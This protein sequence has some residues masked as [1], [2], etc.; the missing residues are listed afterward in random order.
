MSNNGENNDIVQRVHC[1]QAS[2]AQS[3]ARPTG[4]QEVPDSIPAGSGNIDEEIFSLPSTIQ[5]GQ[6]SVSGKRMCT[7]TG[8]PLRGLSLPRKSVVR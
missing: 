8:K 1:K 6:L 3:T 5:E 7:N 4:D 2:V